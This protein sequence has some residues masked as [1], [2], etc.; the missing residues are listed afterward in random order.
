MFKLFIEHH[1]FV[2]TVLVPSHGIKLLDEILVDRLL[3]LVHVLDKI[4]EPVA[5]RAKISTFLQIFDR[6]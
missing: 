5:V 4:D 3:E 6:Y 2:E 1:H